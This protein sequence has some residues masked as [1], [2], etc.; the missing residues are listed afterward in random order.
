MEMLRFWQ[1]KVRRVRESPR[2]E[3][4]FTIAGLTTGYPLMFVIVEGFAWPTMIGLVVGAPFGVL[5]SLCWY[6]TRGTTRP[7]LLLPVVVEVLLLAALIAV[8]C[9]LLDLSIWQTLLLAS[10]LAVWEVV[11]R[12]TMPRTWTEPKARNDSDYRLV[13][14]R[15]SDSTGQ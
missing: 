5:I 12:L 4:L 13:S 10:V 2:G 7:L 6:Q 9:L 14:S 11:F 8:I 3:S 1:E 15:G